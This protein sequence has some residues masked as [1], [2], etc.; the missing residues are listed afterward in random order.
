MYRYL[1]SHYKQINELYFLNNVNY[2]PGTMRTRL[3]SWLRQI[4]TSVI[5]RKMR[6][7]AVTPTTHWMKSWTVQRQIRCVRFSRCECNYLIY[8]KYKYSF[9]VWVSLFVHLLILNKHSPFFSFHVFWQVDFILLGGDL[10]HENKPSR[11]CLHSSITMLR[12][13]CMGDSPVTFNILS[14]QTINFN[15][16]KYVL[17]LLFCSAPSIRAVWVLNKLHV[18]FFFFFLGSRGWTIRMKT[19][20]SL[21]LCSAFMATMMTQLGWVVLFQY[22][23][24]CWVC[25]TWWCLSL[26][27]GGRVV[28]AGSTKCFWSRQSLWPLPV[29]GEDRD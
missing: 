22:V 14:D 21:F 16:T 18:I 12:K 26:F 28:C 29:S 6:S 3:R 17:F 13:Y 1:S 15:T 11:R 23:H 8:L 24:F 20:T 25:I 5:L 10:F 9:L 2:F 7:A 4:F 19:W 27:Q